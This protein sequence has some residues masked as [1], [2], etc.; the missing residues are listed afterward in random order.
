M[1][2]KKKERDSYENI[3]DI[4]HEL[5]EIKKELRAIR[6]SMEFC[7]QTKINPQD[8]SRVVR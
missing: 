1:A 7:H 8:L 2:K 5:Q 3:E 6:S 4:L